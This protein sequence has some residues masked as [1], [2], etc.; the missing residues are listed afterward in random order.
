MKQLFNVVICL[1]VSNVIASAQYKLVKPIFYAPFKVDFKERFYDKIFIQGMDDYLYVYLKEGGAQT[2]DTAIIFSMKKIDLRTD[3]I[4][5]SLQFTPLSKNMFLKDIIPGSDY[6][7][8]VDYGQLFFTRRNNVQSFSKKGADFN[9]G[10][11]LNDSLVLLYTLYNHHPADGGTGLFLNIFNVKKLRF[12]ET[13]VHEFPG[14]IL[15]NLSTNLVSADEHFIYAFAGL[16]GRVFKYDFKLNKVSEST[17][18]FLSDKEKSKNTNYETKIDSIIRHDRAELEHYANENKNSEY[19]S[20]VYSKDFIAQKIAEIRSDFSFIEK[21]FKWKNE[22]VILS[23]SRP[24]YEMD[25]RDL[26]RYNLKTNRTYLIYKKFQ[27]GRKKNL[28]I[29]E[30]YF[31]VDIINDKIIAPYFYKK[32]IYAIAYNDEKLFKS[33]AIDSLDLRLFNDVISRGYQL[34]ILKYKL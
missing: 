6:A 31:V 1:I 26:Y 7:I 28:K 19:V 34:R 10:V 32:Q 14:V 13:V 8:F 24:G 20:E 3:K 22:E 4:I 9:A 16:S 33:G 27:T 23:V 30:D 11:K 25:Y 21:V 18:R 17:V 15:G 2:G 12:E 5:D 29:P